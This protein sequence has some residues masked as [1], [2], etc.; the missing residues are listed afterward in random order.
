M[1]QEHRQWGGWSVK[2]QNYIIIIIIIIII[3]L[4]SDYVMGSIYLLR[5]SFVLFFIF[6][7]SCFVVMC[8]GFV[9]HSM[10]F[11]W[12][13]Y[14]YYMFFVDYIM[15]FIYL[16]RSIF[17]SI[18]IYLVSWL[19]VVQV[20]LFFQCVLGE[21]IIIMVLLR[22]MFHLNHISFLITVFVQF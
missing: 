5:F 17:R 1:R 9:F 21:I 15:G 13:C 2:R 18:I 16:L 20:F 7:W 14:Y 12:N 3:I 8:L 11:G 22:C 4:C 10:C 6:Y 19:W